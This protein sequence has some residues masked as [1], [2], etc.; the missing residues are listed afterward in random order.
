MT[1]TNGERVA[2]T[3]KRESKAVIGNWLHR[4]RLEPKLMAISLSDEKRTGHLAKLLDEV[5]H[6]LLDPL[7]L[8]SEV[9]SYAAVIHGQ[10]RHSQGYTIPMLVEESR[11]LQVSIFET[12]KNNVGT[13]DFHLLMPD[14][15]TVAD[16]VYSQ[17]MQ[18]ISSFMTAEKLS[19]EV[20]VQAHPIAS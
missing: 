12:L 20:P 17:L 14:V 6:R 10:V 8:G 9:D 16:E 15:M 5:V 18:T 4:V 13:V 3:L 19:A 11:I 1:M 7:P 2:A